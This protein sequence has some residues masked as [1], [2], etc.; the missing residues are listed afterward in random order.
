M[1]P[2][3]ILACQMFHMKILTVKRSESQRKMIEDF[4]FVFQYHNKVTCFML[5]Q[6]E[7]CCSLGAHAAV[8]I[9]PT[10]II[11]V[12]RPQVR[13]HKPV[14]VFGKHS[15]FK[16]MTKEAERDLLLAFWKPGHRSA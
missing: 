8:I 12:R 13:T 9:P 1:P 15:S 14:S 10:W 3:F 16:P 6:I 5:Q 4:L 2:P 11:R 7:E